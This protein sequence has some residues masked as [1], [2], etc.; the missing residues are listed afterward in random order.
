MVD[1]GQGSRFKGISNLSEEGVGK[2][3]EDE[4]TEERHAALGIEILELHS[5][6]EDGESV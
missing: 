6:R 1:E 5:A 2:D 4:D 3:E